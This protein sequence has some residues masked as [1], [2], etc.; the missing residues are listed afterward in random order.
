MLLFALA[1]P[2]III[3]MLAVMIPGIFV[4]LKLVFMKI[5]L[6]NSQSNRRNY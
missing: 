4:A 6:A 5:K 3:I 2:I 1:I